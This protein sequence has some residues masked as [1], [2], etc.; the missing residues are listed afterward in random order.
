MNDTTA[1]AWNFEDGQLPYRD[2]LF[3][4][5]LRLTR[6]VEKSEDL[7]EWQDYNWLVGEILVAQED[8]KKAIAN[9]MQ[10]NR[11]NA[12][13][14]YVSSG[15]GA[16]FNVVDYGQFG[17]TESSPTPPNPCDDPPGG[18]GRRPPAR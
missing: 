11:E 15:E 18:R 14:L 7:D 2:Q 13:V 4:T 6:S 10:A 12:R 1:T 5:A 17:G 16:N 8:Y 3:K 9:L